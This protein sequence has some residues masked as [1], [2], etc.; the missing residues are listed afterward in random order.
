MIVKHQTSYRAGS[1]AL[2]LAAVLAAGTARA[3]APATTGRIEGTVEVLRSLSTRKTSFRLYS[4]YG[5]TVMP[6]RNAADT[7]EARNVVIYLDSVAAVGWAVAPSSPAMRQTN[8]AFVP[9]VLAVL[10]GSR[11]EFPN[12]DPVFHNV[13][14][15]SRLKSFDLGRYPKGASRSV[16][17]DKPGIVQVFCHIHADMS[18]VV[19][20]LSN[21]FFATPNDAGRFFIDDIPAGE[22]RV[23]A[24]HERAGPI[25]R[26]V[27]VWPGR[28]TTVDFALPM[29]TEPRRGR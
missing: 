15:L 7:N 4:E 3:Q 10:Q 17:F 22:Y 9:H 16:R 19:L 20:V 6:T 8:G 2:A 5:P 25:V 21:P 14:S 12:G 27:R 18:A 1:L 29:H 13:F 28:T 26:E 24:W 11:V 23:V